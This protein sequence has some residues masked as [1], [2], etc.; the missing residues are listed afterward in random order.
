MVERRDDA[1]EL[2]EL[3]ASLAIQAGAKDAAQIV[4]LAEELRTYIQFGREAMD[5]PA[6]GMPGHKDPA[7]EGPQPDKPLRRE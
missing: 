4:G 5:R 2:R 1:A 7:A 3:C 6:T